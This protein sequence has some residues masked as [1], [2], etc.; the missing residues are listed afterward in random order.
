M[1]E[2]EADTVEVAEAGIQASVAVEVGVEETTVVVV[3]VVDQAAEISEEV[4][5]TIEVEE[6]V[7]EAST[8][9]EVEGVA[10]A[11]VLGNREGTC[12]FLTIFSSNLIQNTAYSPKTSRQL[13]TLGLQTSLKM[14]LS[15]A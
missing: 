7:T 4:V 9:V 2:T 3:V 15:P 11:V 6:A 12:S 13:W 1:E 8:V 14:S 5:E 10:A